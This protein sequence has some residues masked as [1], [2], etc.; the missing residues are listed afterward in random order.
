MEEKKIWG[1]KIKALQVN[2][3]FVILLLIQQSIWIF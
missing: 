2:M 3:M 1:R